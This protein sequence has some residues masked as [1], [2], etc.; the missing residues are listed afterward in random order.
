M[1]E[2]RNKKGGSSSDKDV[3]LHAYIHEYLSKQGF[4]ASAN[5][6]RN[7]AQLGLDVSENS[8]GSLLWDWWSIFWEIYTTRRAQKKKDVNTQNGASTADISLVA[9][10]DGMEV[11]SNNE[12][13]NNNPLR[14]STGTEEEKSEQEYLLDQKQFK[15]VDKN[16][17]MTQF[18]EKIPNENQI[19]REP[20]LDN[21]FRK[22]SEA[23]DDK[24]KE[25]KIDN[26]NFTIPQAPKSLGPMSQNYL[27]FPGQGGRT[28]PNNIY[29]SVPEQRV[30]QMIQL[31]QSAEYYHPN[32]NRNKIKDYPENDGEIGR[33]ESKHLKIKSASD[34][35]TYSP[36]DDLMSFH[37]N[38]GTASGPSRDRRKRTSRSHPYLC[39][40]LQE[41]DMDN[42]RRQSNQR[43][44]DGT[45]IEQR[46]PL[47]TGE[48]FYLH[49]QP[50]SAAGPPHSPLSLKKESLDNFQ[51][52]QHNVSSNNN[53]G[54]ASVHHD[55]NNGS[56]LLVN[57][58]HPLLA[59]PEHPPPPPPTPPDS[60]E[61]SS[62][63]MPAAYHRGVYHQ[64]PEHNVHNM[65]AVHKDDPEN[66][67][68]HDSSHPASPMAQ[69]SPSSSV[70]SS[71]SSSTPSTMVHGCFSVTS[72]GT[73]LGSPLNL[74]SPQQ[75]QSHSPQTGQ[76]LNIP[77][78]PSHLHGKPFHGGP[79]YNPYLNVGP[80][81]Q[82]GAGL[83]LSSH[84][85]HH[86]IPGPLSSPSTMPSNPLYSQASH[87][88]PQQQ[89]QQQQQHNVAIPSHRSAQ[90]QMGVHHLPPH[91]P[92][93]PHLPPSHQVHSGQAAPQMMGI[94]NHLRGPQQHHS[95]PPSG[96]PSNNMNGQPQG[97]NPRGNFVGNHGSNPSQISQA[98]NTTHQN[99][100][101]NGNV[102]MM[103]SNGGGPQS[104]V[105]SSILSPQQHQVPPPQQN[106]NGTSPNLPLASPQFS[107]RPSFSEPFPSLFGTNQLEDEINSLDLNKFSQGFLPFGTGSE[108]NVETESDPSPDTE[109]EKNNSQGQV[110]TELL[111]NGSLDNNNTTNGTGG[112]PNSPN[113]LS[114][115]EVEININQFFAMEHRFGGSQ[116]TVDSTN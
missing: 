89:Q 94:P 34:S 48:N 49:K 82:H 54:N 9:S 77:G 109:R 92:H 91:S 70:S 53:N 108:P 15:S 65:D 85:G 100:N 114:E 97:R 37:Q 74:V 42:F 95:F 96:Y 64:K 27:N 39:S 12:N 93:S 26:L 61:M 46:L 1:E 98:G 19:T 24:T 83:G 104:I 57:S 86:Q 36:G 32:I 30:H 103:N 38:Q 107:G 68:N 71:S 111:A 58:H 87:I 106:Q 113:S 72:P 79:S 105:S 23:F 67:D 84:G 3:T 55:S 80:Y 78:P 16:W 44:H 50:Q 35:K 47:K 22:G 41:L 52:Q 17:S 69:A 76:P 40:E 8:H 81:P 45:L 112:G 59:K 101:G 88:H 4:T 28:W 63:R 6:F 13:E 10:L 20:F 102:H 51:Q 5:L 7:E 116:F 18:S 31:A 115:A 110:Q 21:Q 56:F 62:R 33:H 60:F 11:N 90:F 2:N 43:S 73:P 75:N 14:Y 25:K 99:G 29:P 66:N